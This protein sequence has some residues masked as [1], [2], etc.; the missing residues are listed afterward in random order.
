[1]SIIAFVTDPA[2]AHSILTCLDLPV[3]DYMDGASWVGDTPLSRPRETAHE[4][5]TPE[6][7]AIGAE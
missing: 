2:P 1:M 6:L 4:E 7:V 5:H 3:P